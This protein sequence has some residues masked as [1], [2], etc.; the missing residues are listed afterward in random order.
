MKVIEKIDDEDLIN[1]AAVTQEMI[2]MQLYALSEFHK[3]IMG[4]KGY[5]GKRL[6][7]KTGSTVEQYKVNIKRLKR[8][9]KNI[10]LNSASSDFERMLLKVGFDYLQRS[11]NCIT[12]IYEAGFMSII[13]RSMKRTEI[14][15]GNTDFNNIR[16]IG[17]DLVITDLDKCCYN[18][19][20]MDCFNLLSKYLRKGTELDYKSLVE[21]FCVFENLESNSCDFILAL[22]SYP[23]SFMKCC[24]R[25]REKSKEWDEEEYRDRLEKAILKDGE[26]LW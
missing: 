14:C 16:R 24:N 26:P 6:D 4:Y 9:L 7:N 1:E 17:D 18:N 25:Y 23:Y 5:M 22:L 12:K 10:R 8:Y 11:E 2:E 20:E 19:V 3:K 13:E 15:V 21:K